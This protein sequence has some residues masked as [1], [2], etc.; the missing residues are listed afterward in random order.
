ME[1]VSL[2]LKPWNENSVPRKDLMSSWRIKADRVIKGSQ[3]GVR[4]HEVQGASPSPGATA[5]PC[6]E[7]TIF[8]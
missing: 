7:A 1:L 5:C 3:R 8:K 4:L 6:S 2:V